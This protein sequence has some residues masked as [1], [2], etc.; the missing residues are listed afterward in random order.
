MFGF[1]GHPT[2][3]GELQVG[4]V[5]VDRVDHMIGDCVGGDD[6]RPVGDQGNAD[7]AFGEHSFL[8]A[9]R[10]VVLVGAAI[11]GGEEDQGVFGAA[12]VI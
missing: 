6:T 11:V 7:T 10:E 4:W 1:R 3:A 12:G 2:I 5:V 8:S 9:Q